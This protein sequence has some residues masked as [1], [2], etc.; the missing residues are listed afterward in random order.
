MLL[1]R[2]LFS[3]ALIFVT[4]F[5]GRNY[6]GLVI[7]AN[8]KDLSPSLSQEADLQHAIDS[9][10]SGVE[11][12]FVLLLVGQ[13]AEQVSI[14][15]QVLVSTMQS[16]D[17]VS[18]AEL[19]EGRTTA[20]L[21]L[22]KTYRFQ[23]LTPEQS[24]SLKQDTHSMIAV[25][26]QERLFQLGGS[27]NVLP[28]EQ[29]P[30]AWFTD[31]TSYF[32]EVLGP[33]QDSVGQ[34]SASAP[35]AGRYF[36]VVTA[37]IKHDALDIATQELLSSQLLALEQQL[38][39]DHAVEIYRSGVFFFAADAASTSKSE[40]SLIGVFSLLGIVVLL[41]YVF[42]SLVILLLPFVSIALGV[43]FALAVTHSLFG[44]VHILTVLLGASLLGIVIDYSLHY[45]YHI[46][47][48]RKLTK[49]KQLYHALLLSLATSLIGFAALS[50]SGLPALTKLAVFA[51]SGL[52][53]AWLSVI[54]LASWLLPKA[55]FVENKIM[56]RLLRMIQ[57]PFLS[58]SNRSAMLILSA[59]MSVCLIW[60]YFGASGN[61][62][63]RLFYKP[64]E[65]L[66]TQE[67]L[68]SGVVNDFEPGRYLLIDGETVE[69]VY[70]RFDYWNELVD[71]EGAESFGTVMN[72]VPSP[73]QQA[74]NFQLQSGLYRDNGVVDQLL[75]SLGATG[76][77]ARV[78]QA[79]YL[80][81]SSN[82]LTP[83]A[84]LSQLPEPLNRLWLEHQHKQ[85][86]FVLI[87]KGSD[88][89]GIRAASE[90]VQGVR[91][92]NTIAMAENALKQQRV[93]A[94]WLLVGAYGLI[95]CMLILHFR[96]F[97]SVLMLAVPGMAT[98]ATILILAMLGQQLNL[99]HTMALFLV[100][101]L[102]MDYVIFSK[103]MHASQLTLQAILLSAL[104]TVLSFGLLALSSM[105]VVHA[106]G[107]TLLIGN[108][109]NFLCALVFA[110]RYSESGEGVYAGK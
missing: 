56:P 11:K 74:E 64:A 93:S 110:Q 27:I 70:Q 42:R 72:W 104:T 20:I 13:N 85:Y 55:V 46:G 57:R 60:L 41:V 47:A 40:M 100:L 76:D 69:Q 8:L 89:E 96:S 79:E 17:N 10:S 28:F 77:I 78:L 50:F 63:P 36:Q 65:S 59:T 6:D 103:E 82:T 67:K 3:I 1:W 16:M 105:P 62:D 43:G 97:G 45:F 107:L 35:E 83:L 71:K 21:E 49:N 51:C 101:G 23:L 30:L 2:G 4:L 75:V 53:M 61:D 24:Q 25:A 84:L 15:Y 37:T 102:G 99:F 38:Q 95:A 73:Q 98:A 106:F 92:I 109:L 44:A 14:A 58:L 88:I 31:Y 68:V 26:A 19:D 39:D 90:Q 87:P 94:S 12:R 22:L 34:F 54:C 48:E 7:D 80:R 33:Q 108:T 91:F 52:A 29:D 32:L 86:G 5:F 66:V 9:L 81:S 18:L